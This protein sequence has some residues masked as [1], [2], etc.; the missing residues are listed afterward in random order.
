MKLFAHLQ[1]T[2]RRGAGVL[3]RQAAAEILAFVRSERL[4]KAGFQ[5]PRLGGEDVYYTLFGAACL[6]ALGRRRELFGLR[7]YLKR[8]SAATFDLAHTVALGWLRRGVWL[9]GAPDPRPFR[10]ADGGYHHLL[11]Q[12][13]HGSGYGAYLALLGSEAAGIPFDRAG[14]ADSLRRLQA[15]DGG[16]GN[17]PGE[18]L[19]VTTATA[20]ALIVAIHQ[21]LTLPVADWQAWLGRCARPGGGFAASLD[22]DQAELLSTAVSLFALHLAGGLPPA[23]RTPQARFVEACWHDAGGFADAPGHPQA[24]LEYTFYALLALGCLASPRP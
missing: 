14:V 1:R 6:A 24:D 20:A 5:C 2:A 7:S 16:L 12:A 3:D 17:R 8:Q 23:L 10:A 15:G 21:Q 22:G 13:E 18:S 4:G 19:G 9:R 11:R